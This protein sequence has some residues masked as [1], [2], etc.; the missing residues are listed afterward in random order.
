MAAKCVLIINPA[1]VLTAGLEILLRHQKDINVISSNP[2]S[3]EMLFEVIEHYHPDVMLLEDGHCFV[4]PAY[5][6]SLLK[7]FPD[8]RVMVV[9]LNDNHLQIFARQERLVTCADDLV[10][11]VRQA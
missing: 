11:A 6:V 1:M 5:L 8:L 3:E 7:G 4:Q 2:E 10:D 9:N